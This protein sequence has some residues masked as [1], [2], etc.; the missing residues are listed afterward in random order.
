MEGR[1]DGGGAAYTPSPLLAY[2]LLAYLGGGVWAGGGGRTEEGWATGCGLE[3]EGG[4]WATYT[5]SR[6]LAYALL[7]YLGG[8]LLL[9]A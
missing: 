9:L 6:L 8:G 5:P 2:A 7:A 3:G 1:L 4:G